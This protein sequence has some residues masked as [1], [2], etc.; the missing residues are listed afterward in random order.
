MLTKLFAA[1]VFVLAAFTIHA[2]FTQRSAL[3]L[4]QENQDNYW[5]RHDTQTSG[6]YRSGAWVASPN[7][8][9]YGS[10]RGGGPGAGK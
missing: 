7:R 8:Q 10:F 9:S 5:P 6:T 1:L 4:R 3:L 2:G